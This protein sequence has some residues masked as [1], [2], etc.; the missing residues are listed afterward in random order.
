MPLCGPFRWIAVILFSQT[1]QREIYTG[2]SRSIRRGGLSP[3]ELFTLTGRFF[4]LDMAEDGTIFV[5][6]QNNTLEVLKI[7]PV[8]R[9]GSARCQSRKLF[10]Q[11]SY[12]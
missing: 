7:D 1:P 10:A 4:G 3:Q 12:G 6:Q 9:F 5:D 11:E 8:R 2:S